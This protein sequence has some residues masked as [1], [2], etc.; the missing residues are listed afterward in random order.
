M[1]DRVEGLEAGGDDYLLKPFAFKELRARVRALLRRASGN[2]QNTLPL[3]GGWVMDLGGREL[4]RAGVRADLTRREF[5]LL[6]LLA[7]NSSR[8]FGR[9]E[10]IDRLWT[11][12]TGVEPKVIDVYVSTIRRKTEDS[13]IET[14]RGIGYRLGRGD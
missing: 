6:E 14:L 13:L 7:L 1:E 5:G 11:G 4:Y 8:A 2:A 12:E 3:P 10:I 9:D